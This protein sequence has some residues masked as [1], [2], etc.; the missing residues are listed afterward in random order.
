MVVS[1]VFGYSRRFEMIILLLSG[2][3]VNYALRVSMSVAAPVM[4]DEYGWSVDDEGLVLS[5][6]YWGYAAG[7]IPFSKLAQYVG[8]KP[9]FG[10]SVFCLSLYLMLL[11]DQSIQ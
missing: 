11:Q 7:Q 8:A 3:A 1:F 2:V 10:I 5:S 4:A 6:Y 9:L